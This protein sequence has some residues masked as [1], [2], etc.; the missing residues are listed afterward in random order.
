MSAKKYFDL[1]NPVVLFC[2]LCMAAPQG[3]AKLTAQLDRTRITEGETVRLTI[4]APGQISTMP[5]TRVLEKDFEITGTMSGNRVNI[6]NGNMESRTTWTISLVPKHS[7]VLTIPPLKINGEFT[8]ELT[9][10][11]NEFSAGVN[12]DDDIPIF[13]E[14]EVDISDP[15]V[16]GMVRYTQRVFFAVNL[17]QG[18]LS[19]PEHENALVKKLGEDREYQ[20]LHNGRS[21]QVIERQFVIFPQTS[22]NLVIPAPV[23]NAHIPEHTNRH[24]PFFDR[25]FSSTRPVRLRGEA[26]TLNVRPRPDQS[27]SPYWL[28]AQSVE[29]RETWQPEDDAISFGDPITRNITIEALGI[30]GEQLPDLQ[31]PDPEGFKLYPDRT[32]S[33][34]HNLEHTVRGEKNLR[35]A[36]MPTQSGTQTLP[37]FTLRW[38]DTTTNSEQVATLPK[39]T[40]EVLPATNSQQNAT[41][42]STD[43]TAK[44]DQAATPPAPKETPINPQLTDPFGDSAAVSSK[45]PLNHDGW[46]WASLLFAAL[47]L[48]TAG[49]WWFWWHK[50]QHQP[51]AV[52]TKKL[53]DLEP[54]NARE[55]RKRFLSACQTHNAQ[56]ARHYLIKWAAAHWPESPPRGLE[57]LASRLNNPAISAALKKLDRVLYQ[58]TPENWNGQEL[59]KLLPKLPRHNPKSENSNVLPGLY[60]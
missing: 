21:Y 55:A 38:W 36:Y 6:I 4:E 57:E 31:L 53:S 37:A 59:A 9:L 18:S 35:L 3:Y 28:P 1:F 26:I 7:G 46:F 51:Q 27:K 10:R 60:T 25:F 48:M 52:K 12:S 22:G 13:L 34:T 47:W 45:L 58:N 8:P 39:R 33:N 20:T 30:T 24:D 50:R 11:V 29:L 42:P 14:T 19:E 32:Q 43:L 16:Q 17:S 56:Q 49:L 23:L 54:E 41:A 15:Y 2:L 40:I 5:E 44:T